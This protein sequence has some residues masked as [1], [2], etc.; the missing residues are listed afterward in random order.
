MNAMSLE[1]SNYY[2]NIAF[3]SIIKLLFHIYFCLNYFHLAL[4]VFAL[5]QVII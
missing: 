1:Q 3:V 4:T 5:L 2:L